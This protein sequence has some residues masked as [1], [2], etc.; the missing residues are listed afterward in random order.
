MN[1]SK[2]L[3]LFLIS[4]ILFFVSANDTNLIKEPKKIAYLV[5]DI[6][7]PFWKIMSKGIQ[8]SSEELNYQIEVFDAKNLPKKELENTIKAIKQNVAGIII[9][10][11]NSSNCV[12]VLNLA[13]AANIPVVISDVGTESGEYISYISSNNYEGAYQIG[14]VLSEKMTKNTLS[15]GKVGIIAIPQ[16][17]ENGKARTSGFL[18]AINESNIKGADIRQFK[19]WKDEETYNYVKSMIE[20]HPDLK[21]IWLQTSNTYNGAIKAINDM[22]KKDEILLIAFDAEP[23]FLELIPKGLI[24][25]SGMQQP[26][27]MGKNALYNMDKYLQG[28][29]LEK[30]LQIPILIVTTENIEEKLSTIYLNVLGI[31]KK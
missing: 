19:T 7:I 23:K 31:E 6:K 17:R 11:T 2:I 12:T 4:P 15:R 27:L 5:S 22:N 3:I 8:R 25:G 28:K 26:Y 13:K 21:A 30:N 1:V 24:I 10:P 9:S 20:E 18:K 29:E 16:T 14:K